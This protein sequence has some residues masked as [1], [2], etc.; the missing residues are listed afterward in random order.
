[1]ICALANVPYLSPH[2]LRHGHVVHALR[3]ARNLEDL[4]AI[5]QNV[6]HSSITITDG[7]YGNLAG[8]TVRDTS[9]AWDNPK[10]AIMMW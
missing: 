3:Q 7:I 5:S 6:M 9:P 10:R 2:K 1:M 8:D 4:K